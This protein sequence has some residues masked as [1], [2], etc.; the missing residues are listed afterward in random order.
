MRQPHAPYR[1]CLAS[2]YCAPAPAARE[3]VLVPRIVAYHHAVRD[4]PTT[5]R[6]VVAQTRLTWSTTAALMYSAQPTGADSA[7]INPA[8]LASGT[9]TLPCFFLFCGRISRPAGGL[10][11]KPA[12]HR[13]SE[14]SPPPPPQAPYHLP[15]CPS[16]HLPICLS[17]H[18]PI[19][20]SASTEYSHFPC[21]HLHPASPP[22]LPTPCPHPALQSVLR[23]SS[24]RLRQAFIAPQHRTQDRNAK[25]AADVILGRATCFCAWCPVFLLHNCDVLRLCN[26]ELA[27]L[28]LIMFPSRRVLPSS[29][30]SA[31]GGGSV[32][33]R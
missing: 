22:P 8:A 26:Q 16:A 4:S 12:R 13:S 14:A 31:A 17:A 5:S 19:R 10:H 30:A 15:I 24:R 2:A 23:D 9:S 7:T 6:H 33:R 32:Y 20:P 29:N 21:I 11:P 1:F 25:A 28:A 27:L 3:F 18:L